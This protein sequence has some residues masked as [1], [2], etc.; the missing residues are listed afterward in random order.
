MSIGMATSAMHVVLLI[1]MESRLLFQPH[2]MRL[3]FTDPPRSANC[4]HHG[5]PTNITPPADANHWRTRHLAA[6]IRFLPTPHAIQWNG[7]PK[8]PSTAAKK[9]Q[10]QT[11][12]HRINR[13]N[14]TMIP[15]QTCK[16]RRASG[17]SCHCVISHQRIAHAHNALRANPLNRRTSPV[18]RRSCHHPPWHRLGTTRNGSRF[19]K[20]PTP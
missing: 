9:P 8:P 18:A 10:A 7:L 5:M 11:R 12:K 14:K 2:P 17:R 16:V 6:R 20:I 15:L 19:D 3:G 1:F 13:S 4:R